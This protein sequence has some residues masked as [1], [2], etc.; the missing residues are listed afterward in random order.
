MRLGLGI[1]LQFGRRAGGGAAAPAGILDSYT[2]AA[3]AFAPD[4][5]IYSAHSVTD[6]AVGSATNGQAGQYTVR[7]RRSSDNAVSS[8]TYTEVSDG[9]LT[10]WVGASNDGFVEA[11]YDQSGNGNHAT[12]STAADQPKIV[13]A[14]SLVVENGKAAIL[15]NDKEL[16]NNSLIVN[17]PASEFFVYR[18]I[19]KL[20]GFNCYYDGSGA[21]SQRG[22][23]GTNNASP[24]ST[25]L[26]DGTILTGTL[27]DYQQKIASILR[28]S[29]SSYFYINNSIDASGNS[30]TQNRVGL[31]IGRDYLKINPSNIKYQMLIIYPS[32]QSSN[33][34][35]IESAINTEYSIY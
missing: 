11:A 21:I 29:T 27:V 10:T 20:D 30:G 32:D 18:P 5:L 13:D 28:A 22:Y 12:Q 14:G 3:F 6:S 34:T 24:S 8:F 26:F 25:I 4:V 15:T 17:Q 23:F 16:E 2:G 9:T 33:R 7:V 35:A 19:S 31:T 1:G